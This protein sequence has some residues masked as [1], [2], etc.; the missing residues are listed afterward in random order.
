P[1]RRQGSRSVPLFLCACSPALCLQR[2]GLTDHRSCRMNLLEALAP[3]GIEEWQLPDPINIFMRTPPR[4]Q[5]PGSPGVDRHLG[6]D[7]GGRPEYDGCVQPKAATTWC[8][9]ASG[10]GDGA[11]ASTA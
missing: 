1:R 9:G 10:G 6:L 4:L 3:Y 5:S 8:R 11:D 7:V 2:F